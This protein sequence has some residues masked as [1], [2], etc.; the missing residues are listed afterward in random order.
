MKVGE[1][2]DHTKLEANS[3]LKLNKESS[4]LYS[5]GPTKFYR[6]N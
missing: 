6:I 3:F 2:K 4:Q 1:Q 5:T